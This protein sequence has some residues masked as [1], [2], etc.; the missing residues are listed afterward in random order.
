MKECMVDDRQRK[1]MYKNMLGNSVTIGGKGC[2]LLDVRSDQRRDYKDLDEQLERS[3]LRRRSR[4]Q[5]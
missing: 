5:S 3:L 2:Q 4:S 1:K